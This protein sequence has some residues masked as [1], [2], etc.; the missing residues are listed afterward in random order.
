MSFRPSSA[1]RPPT[2]R[3]ALRLP[4]WPRYLVPVLAGLIAFGVLI[5]IIAG[6][7]TD[8]LWYHSV[9]YG[10]VFDVIYGTRWALFFVVGIFMAAVVGVNAWLAYRLRPMYRPAATERPGVDAYRMAIDPHR[11]LLLGILLGLIGLI[12]GV[13]ASGAWRTWLLFINQVPFGRKDAQFGLDI[14]FFV[15]TYPFLRLVLSYLFAAVLLS[16]VVAAAVHVLYGGLGWQARRPRATVA[17]QAHLF[18]LVGVFVLLKGAAYWVDRWGVDF[19]QRGAVTTGASYT[20]VNAVL[21]AKTVLAVIAVLCAVLF[22]AG[23]VRRSALLPAVGFG[24]LVLSAILIGGVYPAIIQQFV[25]KP[26]ELA[27]ETPYIDREIKATRLAY[28][29]RGAQYLGYSGTSSESSDE[30]LTQSS[31]LPGFRLMDPAVVS[32][33][34][35]Q[36]QQVKGFYQ[37]PD[38][39]SVDRYVLP[40]QRQPQDLVVAVR[41]LSGPPA[42]QGNWINTHL[43]YTH[44]FGFVAAKENSVA[45]GGTPDFVESDIPP[46]GQLGNFEPRV[47]FG[48]AENN[49]VIVGGPPH[50]Q[51]GEERDYPFQS[52]SGQKN[53]TYT[54]TGGVPVGSP[55]NRLLY[56]IK[57]RELNI[58]L[59]GAINSDSKILYERSPLARVAK[60][61]PCLTLDGASYPVVVH[62]PG[63]PGR[64]LWVVDGYTTTN[65]YPYSQRLGMPAATSTSQTPAGNLAGQP[66]GSVNYVRNSV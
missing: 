3:P 7:W 19:S 38:T 5:T 43:V 42:G 63:Q 20:D 26:N 1:D 36:L 46:Q 33:A 57:F 54:G 28:A 35:Q 18:V 4:R 14:S 52:S 51:G 56:A 60:V 8:R 21:P 9:Q 59:S 25:V 23:A 48:Q 22:F 66:T 39:L 37:F 10:S 61:A 17:T 41:G 32:R 47:Y 45:G 49:Y 6:V 15:F 53:Y 40:G 27:K 55:L 24:L 50:A 11:R 31:S 29:V 62:P 30:L 16:L 2:G 34:F 12:S 13:T 64:I 58:L 44:G 65:L